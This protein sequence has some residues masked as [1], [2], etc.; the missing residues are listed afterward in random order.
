MSRLFDDGTPDW[1]TLASAPALVA[2]FTMACWVR[3]NDTT[4]LQ[5]AMGLFRAGSGNRYH[6][7]TLDGA[8]TNQ[9]QCTTREGS[10]IGTSATGTYVVDTWHHI[11]GVW[12]SGTSRTAYFE[13]VAG[14]ANTLNATPTT[15]DGFAIGRVND[16]TPSDPFSGNIAEAGFWDVALTA[17]E[18]VALAGGIS[19]LRVR[20]ESLVIY[21]P[22][23]GLASP[24]PDYSSN[25]N[26]L[27]LNGT[28]SQ[29]E[30]APVAPP[31]GFGLGWQG[32]FT[33]AAADAIFPD[34][35]YP[36]IQQPY[37]HTNQVVPYQKS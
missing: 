14:T 13:G 24:E 20:S 22:L 19:P 9:V 10:D 3:S 21:V 28:P 11:G 6:I 18:M 17:N 34:S 26:D 1:L 16:G 31:F 25:G 33:A 27:T 4:I 32:A 37:P 2:P 29:D 30:H 8:G 23:Y 5:G 7:L 36:G 12:A 15:I 35:W